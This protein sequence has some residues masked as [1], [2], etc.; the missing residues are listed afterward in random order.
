MPPMTTRRRN[1]G[2]LQVEPTDFCNLT[3]PMCHPQQGFRPNLHGDLLKG[4]MD[5]ELF[6]RIVDGIERSDV[7]FDHLIFQW[8]GDP[9]LHPELFE[10]LRYAR[11][12]VSDRFDYFR[13]DTN[14][15]L[16]TPDRTEQLIDA[17]LEDPR[18]PVLIVF[19]LDAIT[20]ETYK[21]AKGRDQFDVVMA[22]IH[23]FLRRRGELELETITLNAEFQFVLQ[24][25]NAHEA[26]DFVDHWDRT[27]AEGR[28]GVGYNDIMVKRVSVGTGGEKQHAA[29]R[30]Y[31]ETI[32]RFG[33]A[34]FKKDHIEL[35][36]WMERAWEEHDDP[37][38]K[39]TDLDLG[40][41]GLAAPTVA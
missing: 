41:T 32:E 15:I 35:K 1:C 17:Y 38:S 20:K 27:C 39:K 8:L 29:D 16:L 19:S 30:L 10:M 22:N 28:N 2:V 25:M 4:Y 24:A 40:K 3:C 34:P 26:R 33:L 12:K 36:I 9:S 11:R 31:A 23:H 14:A 5:V 18:V 7:C 13:I 6:S 21:K 37:E